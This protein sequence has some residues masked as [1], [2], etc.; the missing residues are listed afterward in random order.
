MIVPV[1][2]TLLY[3]RELPISSHKPKADG[4]NC[5]SLHCSEYKLLPRRNRKTRSQQ[6]MCI[7]TPFPK[8]SRTNGGVQCTTNIKKN[9][10]SS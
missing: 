3:K 10:R 5:Y 1:S 2:V 4:G 7:D 9:K 6:H 8:S